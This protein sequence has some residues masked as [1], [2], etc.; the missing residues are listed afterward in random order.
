MRSRQSVWLFVLPYECPGTPCQKHHATSCE[1]WTSRNSHTA[2][3][4]VRNGQSQHAHEKVP[5]ERAKSVNIACWGHTKQRSCN[6]IFGHVYVFK[7]K[8]I[9]FF[10]FVYVQNYTPSSFLQYLSVMAIQ[11]EP[12]SK[13]PAIRGTITVRLRI[14]HNLTVYFSFRFGKTS[15]PFVRLPEDCKSFRFM[16]LQTALSPTRKIISS[17][18]LELCCV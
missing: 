16:M 13:K 1:I 5:Q 15:K 10:I 8:C 2:S 14:Y 4:P 11:K 17:N 3:N 18:T 7:E 9:S 6:G 12:D